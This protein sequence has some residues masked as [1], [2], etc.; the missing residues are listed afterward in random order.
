MLNFS[1]FFIFILLSCSRLYSF[2]HEHLKWDVLLK[3]HVKVSEYSSAVDYA[4]FLKEFNLLKSYN[5]SL[6]EVSQS[7]YDQ[8]NS[9]Q[10]M[11]FLINA[12]N[13]FTVELILNNYPVSSIRSFKIAI[14]SPWKKEFFNLLG[15]KRNLDWIE[16][17]NLRV[18]FS[19]AR[20]H[21]AV[22]CASIGCPALN[23]NAFTYKNLEEE[24]QRSMIKFLSD[25][26][27]NYVDEKNKKLYLSQIFFWFTEDF[28][29]NGSSVEKFVAN[30]ITND[31]KQRIEIKSGKFELDKTDYN[32]DL[33]DIKK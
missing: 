15:K 19:E 11:A 23:E 10:Q 31:E 7:E 21:F 30:Y 14:G 29:K 17:K 9:K 32:W 25:K 1:S 5:K 28:Q 13:S 6:S 22:N 33:N 18:K 2:D 12:Y 4:S 20:I 16:H 3:K 24:L 8:W 27:R 26:S